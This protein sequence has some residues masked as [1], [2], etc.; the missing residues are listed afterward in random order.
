VGETTPSKAMPLQPVA[1]PGEEA[2]LLVVLFL[3]VILVDESLV[4]C[5]YTY[6]LHEK[7]HSGHSSM[8]FRPSSRTSA[9]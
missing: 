4:S 7:A 6:P 9:G 2:P 3:R 1:P 8:F 5:R